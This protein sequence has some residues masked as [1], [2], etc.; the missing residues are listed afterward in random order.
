MQLTNLYPARRVFEIILVVFLP[1]LVG[2]GGG[3]GTPFS[4]PP[5]PDVSIS[6]VTR[7]SQ[8][9]VDNLFAKLN[10]DGDGW[11]TIMES[12]SLNIK[13]D[14][15]TDDNAI[16]AILRKLPPISEYA[17]ASITNQYSRFGS[18]YSHLSRQAEFPTRLVIWGHQASS[19][20]DHD[21]SY[22][23]TSLWNCVACSGAFE[24]RT[25]KATGTLELI[26]DSQEATLNL[27]GDGLDLYAPLLINK[28]VAFR[29]NG[30]MQL[31]LDEVTQP[32][33]RQ[34]VSGTL[35]GTDASEAGM[36]IGLETDQGALFSIMAL[37]S[38]S[39]PSATP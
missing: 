5:P 7:A 30:Y 38:E 34:F 11:I 31:K 24:T 37:G 10:G 9:Q 20:P 6:D 4:A 23:M 8:L 16:G 33:N 27:A 17:T 12:D 1:L 26:L 29:P 25:G 22:E 19:L 18:I 2:C 21:I 14:G 28:D 32:L 39:D 36:I 3:N 15:V 35:F 13:L